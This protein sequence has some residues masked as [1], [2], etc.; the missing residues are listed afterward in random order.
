MYLVIYPYTYSVYKEVILM[1]LL[2]LVRQTWSTWEAKGGCFVSTVVSG[3][4][5]EATSSGDV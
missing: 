5:E 3:M 1:W 2:H 4:T